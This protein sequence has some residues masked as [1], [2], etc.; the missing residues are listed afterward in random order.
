ME[1][2]PCGELRGDVQT[3]QLLGM[4]ATALSKSG[5]SGTPKMTDFMLDFWDDS[6][7]EITGNEVVNIIMT[8]PGAQKV[9]A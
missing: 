1:T 4:I 2:E 3:A 6:K 5:G 8:L 9:K 7:N